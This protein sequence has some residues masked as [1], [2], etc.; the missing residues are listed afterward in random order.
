LRGFS[1]R[2]AA[3]RPGRFRAIFSLVFGLIDVL[4]SVVA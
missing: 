3:W 1:S 2:N 4:S